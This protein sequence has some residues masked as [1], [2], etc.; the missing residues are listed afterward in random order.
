MPQTKLR[1]CST[2]L[3]F[4]EAILMVALHWSIIGQFVRKRT[5]LTQCKGLSNPVWSF[6]S[7][8]SL[9]LL[10]DTLLV[11]AALSGRPGQ[12]VMASHLEDIRSLSRDLLDALDRNVKNCFLGWN[13]NFNDSKV[14][15]NFWIEFRRII[16]SCF[17]FFLGLCWRDC[18]LW[19]A[20][21]NGET[22]V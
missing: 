1:D 16:T 7:S 6:F 9:Q 22:Q 2:D 20:A 8:A 3:R 13:Q 21:G 19:G 10:S 5:I 12:K 4:S 18:P 17:Y 15:S 14:N 11:G